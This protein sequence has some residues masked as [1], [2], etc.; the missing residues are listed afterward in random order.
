MEATN[1]SPQARGY[2]GSPGIFTQNQ[3]EGWKLVT[4]AVHDAGA[5]AFL[6]L[7]HTG[8]LGHPLNQQLPVSASAVSMEDVASHAITPEGRKDY[9][10][11]RALETEEI[12][13]IIEDYKVA[14]KNALAAG[15]DGV[16]LHAANGYLL[17]QFLCD[18][19]NKRSDN[20]GGS[21]E[22]RARFMLEALEGIL[23]A[24]DSS[25]VAIRL[26]PFGVTFGC[27]DSNPRETY[28]YVINKLSDYNLAYLHVVEPF[29]WEV[30]GDLVPEGG[31]SPLFR[32]LYKGPLIA[33][34]GFDRA[35]A[36]KVV[37]DG[38]DDLIGFGRDFIGTP[39]IVKR[40]KLNKPFNKYN[41]KT[42]YV[43]FDTPVDSYPTGYT[44]YPKFED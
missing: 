34:G 7:W 2:Y 38:T 12:S 11:P 42:F 22:N 36:I 29:G 26:S 19:T 1:I 31:I 6:Q 4:K 24:A 8:R 33:T 17:E 32:P 37:E 35:K 9:V 16:E 27:T 39:D 23:S 15:F 20:Y 30:T 40:L 21:I 28:G 10:T 43:S 25:Q 5:K 18:K 41:Q 3:V 14:T 44:D 13:S